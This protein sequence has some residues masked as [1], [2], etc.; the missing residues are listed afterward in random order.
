M[1]H[2]YALVI[3]FLMVSIMLWIV[4]GLFTDLALGEILSMAA[5]IT[6]IAYLVGDILVLSKFNNFTATISDIVLSCAIIYL[7]NYAFVEQRIG[8]WDAFISAVLIGIGEWFF[9]I[10]MAK[11]VFPNAKER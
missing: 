2:I 9:H 4:L 8:F 6:S 11:M 7:Y 10:Y 3:K 5:I 1:K